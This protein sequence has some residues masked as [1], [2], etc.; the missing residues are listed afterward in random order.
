MKREGGKG[1]GKKK[2]R[3]KREMKVKTLWSI[4]KIFENF[5]FF[6]IVLIL[7]YIFKKQLLN[8]YLKSTS[9]VFL[10]F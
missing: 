10:S 4:L 6:K 1:V 5:Y 2:K 9:N 8:V 7:I 3:V